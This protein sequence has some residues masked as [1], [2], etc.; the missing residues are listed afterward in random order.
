MLW[1]TLIICNNLQNSIDYEHNSLNNKVIKWKSK[2]LC[3]IYYF[4]LNKI[5][6]VINFFFNTR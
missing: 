2:K 1:E 6:F 5:L 3:L 4:I